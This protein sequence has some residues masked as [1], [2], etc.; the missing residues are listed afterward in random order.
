MSEITPYRL[1]SR[2]SSRIEVLLRADSEDIV[3]W[4]WEGANRSGWQTSSIESFD[5]NFEPAPPPLITENLTFVRDVT[6]EWVERTGYGI[7]SSFR[8]ITVHP[9]HT[10]SENDG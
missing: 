9:D 7:S 3:L 8:S 10:W 2:P 5:T 6:G 1:V 4:R